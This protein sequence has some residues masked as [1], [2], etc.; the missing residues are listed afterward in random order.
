VHHWLRYV[1]LVIFSVVSCYCPRIY[2]KFRA[3]KYFSNCTTHTNI[4]SNRTYLFCRDYS[5]DL[6]L[7]S[8]QLVKTTVPLLVILS[9]CSIDSL[10]P[11]TW[12][13][14]PHV[15]HP[16]IEF[17]VYVLGLRTDYSERGWG[18]VWLELRIF[19]ASNQHSNFPEL[20]YLLSSYRVSLERD[21][22][23]AIT[24]GSC[25]SFPEM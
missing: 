14:V 7:P 13:F 6:S 3:T 24:K 21:H 10:L 22:I 20:L 5:L 18:G 17:H 23:M 1:L 2:L 25:M 4:L 11:L 8:E 19:S 15:G 9:R 16:Q 12:H